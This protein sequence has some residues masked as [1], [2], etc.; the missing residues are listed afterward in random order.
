MKTPNPPIASLPCPY[1]SSFKTGLVAGCDEVGR[2]CLA[3]PLVAAAVILPSDYSQVLIKDSKRLSPKQRIALGQQIRCD[4]LDW[5]I[6]LV[7][8]QEIDA[9]NVLQASYLAMH[10][11]IDQL[12]LRPTHLL[13]DGRSFRAYPGISH[14]CIVKGDMRC[15]SIAAASVIAKV[16]RDEYME[17]LAEMVKGYDWAVN[18]GYPTLAHRKAIESMGTSPHHRK[19]FKQLKLPSLWA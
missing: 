18:K 17:D 19:S 11:A 8:V 13:I 9:Y 7:S 12:K 14:T 6:G 16:Y 4:A 2:G 1:C 5:A 15:S 3:G 10:R